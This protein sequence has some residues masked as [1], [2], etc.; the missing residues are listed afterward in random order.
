MRNFEEH[1]WT[2]T[3]VIKTA[4]V[5]SWRLKKL[6][7]KLTNR[8]YSAFLYVPI[9][10]VMEKKFDCKKRRTFFYINFSSIATLKNKDNDFLCQLCFLCLY[11]FWLRHAFLIPFIC[12]TRHVHEPTDKSKTLGKLAST[13]VYDGNVANSCFATSLK[14]HFGMGVLL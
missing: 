11:L 8:L 6:L 2:T 9:K 5:E 1:L 13:K 3:S 4:D 7:L 14:S 12:E 10:H